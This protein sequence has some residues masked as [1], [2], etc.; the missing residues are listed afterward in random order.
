MNK[1][2]QKQKTKICAKVSN[3]GD[4]ALVKLPQCG[5]TQFPLFVS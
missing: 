4:A 5:L 3:S 1:T 2:K